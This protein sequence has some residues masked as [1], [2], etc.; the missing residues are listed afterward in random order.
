MGWFSGIFGANRAH[1]TGDNL[2]IGADPEHLQ[3]VDD[4]EG[5]GGYQ[6]AL[7]KSARR[8]RSGYIS[9]PAIQRT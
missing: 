9:G 4:P 6:L 3:P 8:P 7:D 5:L 1:A 2:W